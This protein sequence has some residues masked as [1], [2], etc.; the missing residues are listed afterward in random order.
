M[1]WRER[2]GGGEKNALYSGHLRLCQQPRAAHALRSDQNSEK[3][4]GTLTSCLSI[5]QY[6]RMYYIVHLNIVFCVHSRLSN[7]NFILSNLKECKWP[8]SYHLVL[9][10]VCQ[11]LIK[12]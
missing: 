1:S 2:G 11:F 8:K 10:F 9:K 3:G 7:V 6:S 12:S 4:W 5:S